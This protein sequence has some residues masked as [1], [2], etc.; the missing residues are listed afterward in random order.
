MGD[1]MTRHCIE[2]SITT[3]ALTEYWTAFCNV[4]YLDDGACWIQQAPYCGAC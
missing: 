3:E 4:N 2:F 1:A